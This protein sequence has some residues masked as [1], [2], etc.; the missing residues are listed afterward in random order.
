METETI[1][2]DEYLVNLADPGTPRYLKMEI[3]LEISGLKL[4]GGEHGKGAG[5]P[6]ELEAAIN[7]AVVDELSSHKYDELNTPEGKK[8][9]K[10]RLHGV[11]ARSLD[12]KCPE[13]QLH[14]VL[15]MSFVMQ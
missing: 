10:G 7:D 14:K 4:S 11:I 13:A 15:F 6:I 1:T 9:L 12:A 5:L 3:A 8:R 2:L